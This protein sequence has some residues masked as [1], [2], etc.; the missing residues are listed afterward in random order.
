MVVGA[1]V[2]LLAAAQDPDEPVK[3]GKWLYTRHCAG[4]HN[5]N[6]DGKG[7]TILQLGLQA[8]D[9]QQG[10]FAFGD[11][12]EQM[13]RTITSGIPGRSPMPSFKGVLSDEEMDLVIGHVRTLMPARD[14]S[15][16]KNTELIVKGRPLIARGK[17]PPIAE[18]AKEVPRGLLIGTPEGMTFEY[19]LDGVKLL[20]VRL[21]R[22]ADREDWSDRGGAYLKPLG[23]LVWDSSMPEVELL[24]EGVEKPVRVMGATWATKSG[25]GISYMTCKS[26]A[27]RKNSDYVEEFLSTRL[28]STGPSAVRNWIVQ[29]DVQPRIAVGGEELPRGGRMPRGVAKWVVRDRGEIG[30][31]A[32][33]VVYRGGD[34][35]THVAEVTTTTV[36]VP[37]W[38]DE[39]AAQLEKELGQ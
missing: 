2:G 7:E 22:F 20:G 8:R 3:D 30:V 32:T 35:A 17:L 12:R 16:P 26:A 19:D 24:Y 39:I 23:Q 15:P 10:G 11:S 36:R 38:T 5:H 9:F 6:G 13:K 31:D 1:F 27:D 34:S 28:L 14:E 29:S 37:K 33:L 25:T 4:C 18:G 21:G